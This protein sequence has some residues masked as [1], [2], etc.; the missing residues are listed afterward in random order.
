MK[1]IT[2]SIFLVINLITFLF[3]TS[4]GGGGGSEVP[5]SAVKANF[6]TLKIVYSGNGGTGTIT[7]K[8]SD[9]SCNK[10]CDEK[11]PVDNKVTLVPKASVDSSFKGYGV[12]SNPDCLD[13][14][15]TMSADI[16]CLPIFDINGNSAFYDLSITLAGLGEGSVTSGDTEINCTTNNDVACTKRYIADASVT[17]TPASATGST[18]VGWSG[19]PE[20]TA[21]VVTGTSTVAITKAINCIATFEP[22]S[23]DVTLTVSLIGAGSGSVVSIPTSPTGIN[24]GAGGTK[25]DGLYTL[26][27]SITLQAAPALEN[28]FLIWGADCGSNANT[29]TLDTSITMSTTKTCTASFEPKPSVILYNLS[30][31]SA[32][33]AA[34]GGRIVSVPN[35]IDCG[36]VCNKDFAEKIPVKLTASPINA[37]TKFK[38]WGG[39][40]GI[41]TAPNVTVPMIAATSCVANFDVILPVSYL[42]TVQIN[43]GNGTVSSK[44]AG[45][46]CGTNCSNTYTANTDVTLTPAVV[47]NL[48]FT[49]WTGAGCASGIVTMSQNR[50]CTANF[51]TPT[52]LLYPLTVT[53]ASG[54]ASGTVTPNQTGS[55][56]GPDCQSYVQG[57]VISLE[58]LP[59]PGY[60]LKSWAGS[61]TGGTGV[62]TTTGGIASVTIGITPLS[63]TVT[64]EPVPAPLYDLVI[65]SD[66]NGGSVKAT[67][68]AIPVFDCG[69]GSCRQGYPA[70]TSITLV[71]TTN[72]GYNFTGWGATCGTSAG[73]S[74]TTLTMTTTGVICAANFTLIPMANLTINMNG[75]PGSGTVT[76]TDSSS[77]VFTCNSTTS[78]T[79]AYPVNE[80]VTLTQSATEPNYFS[81]W[82]GCVQGTGAASIN[83]TIDTAKTC[84]IN[85]GAGWVIQ[86]DKL[87]LGNGSVEFVFVGIDNNGNPAIPYTC[88]T[89]PCSLITGIGWTMTIT[90]VPDIGST[91][92][93]WTGTGCAVIN[94]TDTSAEVISDARKNCTVTFN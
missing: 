74:T 17:L 88:T 75:G 59:A 68:P 14:E 85:F 11:F 21:N 32:G 90:A 34:T 9:I 42:L 37:T 87:G 69:A 25:C 67:L 86:I 39:D 20:C 60:Q 51:S 46:N 26:N 31:S 47:G 48:I 45:I 54:A 6:Y 50:I 49:G 64:F 22:S 83:V 13:G 81:S 71:A 19:D 61:C 1:M 70:G 3:L 63:C 27:S 29:T 33:A 73:T 78:C 77:G 44:P 30:V 93:G 89:L 72:A 52:V 10:S 43:G 2:R 79:N 80:S 55:S 53:V 94:S 8:P 92:G 28:N 36:T 84:I 41:G 35:G 38:N 12:G 76:V 62:G 7:L 66:L 5:A 82:S 65:R 57:T 91:F 23:T 58:A 15:V 4:C 40:C 16:S 18:F 56:C 24:C